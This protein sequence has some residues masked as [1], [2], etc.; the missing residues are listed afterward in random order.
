M[1]FINYSSSTVVAVL[2]ST[3]V[4]VQAAN[5]NGRATPVT[6]SIC[7]DANRPILNPTKSFTMNNGNTWTCHYLQETVQDVD[8]NS[9]NESERLMCAQAQLQ[10]ENGGC[11][12]GGAAMAPIQSQVS[13]LNP[14]CDLCAG[15][16]SAVVPSSN[17]DKTVATGVAGTHNCQ[18]LYGAMASG[19]I[20]STLCPAIQQAAG[21][22]CCAN[23]GS[24]NSNLSRPPTTT[25]SNANISYNT[26]ASTSTSSVA[27]ST[28]VSTPQDNT[29]GTTGSGNERQSIN[30]DY[31]IKR[32]GGTTN[33]RGGRTTSSTGTIR[34]AAVPLP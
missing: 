13:Q 31:T 6:C 4:S 34:G 27:S 30:S 14:A 20:S 25:G 32:M 33:A 24:S 29:A 21:A 19:T 17:Y 22:T 10:G 9:P 28:P 26:G 15:Q 3:L 7:R 23:N 8:A 16:A 2:L 12:C 1:M 11:H 5:W 18:G